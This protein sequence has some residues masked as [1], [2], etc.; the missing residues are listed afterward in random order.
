MRSMVSLDESQRIFSELR[1]EFYFRRDTEVVTLLDALGRILAEDVFSRKDMPESD[2]AT[3]DGF[4]VKSSDSPPL[5]IV[6]EIFPNYEGKALLK[7]GEAYYITTGSPLPEGADAVIK[8]ELTDQINGELHFA[9]KINSGK[10]V[11]KKGSE[12]RKGEL[13]MERGRRI[14]PQEIAV[15]TGL[16]YER[17]KV[18]RKLRVAVFSNGDEIKAGKLKDINSAMIMSFVREWG[19][20]AHFLGVAGDNYDEVRELILRGVSEYDVVITS[21]GVSVGKKDYVIKV[22]RD[23]GEMVLYKIRQRPGKPMAVAVVEG[24]PVFALPGKP[25]GAFVAMLSLRKFF[26]GDRPYPKV[27]LKMAKGVRIPTPGFRY[28]VF[29]KVIDGLAFPVGYKDSPISILPDN[30]PYEVSVISNMAR[31]FLAD[32]F[33]I[34]EKDIGEGEEVEVS[35]YE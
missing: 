31:S 23:L 20:E 3:M 24:K 7:D 29:I 11:L 14:G 15:L 18:L 17:V 12:V 28:I 26:V 34:A 22:M 6:G 2:I 33:L 25:G 19:E 16:G 21:G 5:K 8:V 27:K 32:G 10:Y 13:V 30:S 4:A 35:L 1:E 9:G